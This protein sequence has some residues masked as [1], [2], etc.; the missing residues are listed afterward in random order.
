MSRH[1]KLY[2]RTLN[3]LNIRQCTIPFEL[4]IS[5][6]SFLSFEPGTVTTLTP[7]SKV[8][9]QCHL[10]LTQELIDRF[11]SNQLQNNE[12]LLSKVEQTTTVEQGRRVQWREQ[13]AVKFKQNEMEQLIPI[14]IRL[15][16]PI[17]SVNC[18]R[19]DFGICFLEQT[20]QRELIVKNLTCSSSAWSIRKGK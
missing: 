20:R 10:H 18:D 3:L 7:Q 17:L 11:Q 9:V 8:Q 5:D 19:I 14:D 15:Y 1:E 4:S 13:L 6:G 2:T 16:Y 12:A